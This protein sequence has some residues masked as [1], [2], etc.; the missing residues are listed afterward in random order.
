MTKSC[1]QKA[2]QTLQ[3]MQQNEIDEMQIYQQIAANLKNEEDRKILLQIAKEEEIHAKLW[4]QYTGNQPKPRKFKVFKTVLL[5]KIFGYTFALKM[6][7]NGEDK[8]DKAYAALIA[9]I[10]EAQK[11][12]EDEERHEQALLAMLDEERLQFVGS[13]VLGMNDALVELTGTLAGLTFALQNNRLVALSGLITGISATFSMTASAYLSAKSEN[14]PQALKSSAYT[15]IMY[16][17]TVALMS[18]PFLLLPPKAYL[19]ALAVLLMIVLL[20]IL[21]FNYYISVAKNYH[22]RQRFLEMLIISGSV[23]VLSFIVGLL[24]K[25]W[26]GIDI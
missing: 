22:F 11:I 2:L 17:I 14:D 3:R 20:I 24:V 12:S 6:M 26:L 19:P 21:I 23:A 15:G 13:M 4:E 1:S 25:A 9:E 5:A 16:L 7:E 8:A 18:L 10:P